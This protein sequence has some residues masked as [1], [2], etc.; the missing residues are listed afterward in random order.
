MQCVICPYVYIQEYVISLS[1]HYIKA[2]NSSPVGTVFEKPCLNI[3]KLEL[4]LTNFAYS[5][6]V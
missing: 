1:L 2:L 4:M 5:R 3:S 6:G